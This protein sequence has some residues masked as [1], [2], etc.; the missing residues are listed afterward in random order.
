MLILYIIE[1]PMTSNIK[2]KY[3]LYLKGSIEILINIKREI[4]V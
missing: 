3:M 4:K 2:K 1:F